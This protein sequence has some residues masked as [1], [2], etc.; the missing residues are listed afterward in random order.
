MITIVNAI[1][2]LSIRW[3]ILPQTNFFYFAVMIA[4][5]LVIVIVRFELVLYPNH[6]PNL[7]HCLV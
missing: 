2:R 1:H 5:Y 6:F 7:L 4:D 3:A